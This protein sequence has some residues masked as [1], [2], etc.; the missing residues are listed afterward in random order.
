VRRSKV[1]FIIKFKI[2]IFYEKDINEVDSFTLDNWQER[3]L[4]R[5]ERNQSQ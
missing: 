2:L 4:E 3:L 1:S 5:L